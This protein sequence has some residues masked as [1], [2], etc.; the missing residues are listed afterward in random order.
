M[1]C[2]PF[3]PV[4]YRRGSVRDAP[5]DL[6]NQLMRENLEVIKRKEGWDKETLREIT[7][8]LAHIASSNKVQP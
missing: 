2:P 6:R 3:I 4:K 8:T 5:A 7:T 1:I